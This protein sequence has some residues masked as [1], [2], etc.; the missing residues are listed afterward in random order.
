MFMVYWTLVEG[1][2][3]TPHAQSFPAADMGAAL[4]LMEQLRVRQRA[5]EGI[6]FVTMSSENPE[7]VGHPGVDATGQ[8]Y[9]WTK[10]RHRF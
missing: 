2:Q 3:H 7:S 8:G 9:R 10:R 4:A 6:R 1:S 5:G